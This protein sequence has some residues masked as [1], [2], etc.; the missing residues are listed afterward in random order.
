[1]ENW[2]F[3]RYVDFLTRANEEPA[4]KK[5]LLGMVDGRKVFFSERIDHSSI[6]AFLDDA[7]RFAGVEH[8]AKYTGDRLVV[9]V[10]APGEGFVSFID[11]WD[12]D[13][14]ATVNGAP[15]QIERLFGTFKSVRVR[16]GTQTVR[17]TYRPIHL[18]TAN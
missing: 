7:R 4:E 3:K 8:I 9:R 10:I 18:W 5:Y 2:Y 12:P 13:W 17:F 1:M 16:G 14:E 15:A 11:N 6:R